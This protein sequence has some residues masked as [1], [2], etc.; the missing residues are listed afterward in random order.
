[1]GRRKLRPINVSREEIGDEELERL[2]R[3]WDEFIVAVRRARARSGER[4]D[5]LTL[6][7]YEFLRPLR[8]AGGMQVTHLADR[9]G[10]APGTATGILDG[11]ARLGFIERT[12]ASED[13]RTVTI[14]LTDAGRQ[15]VE[16][17]RRSIARQ[18]R[19]LFASIAPEERGHTERMLRHLARVITEL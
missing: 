7:Q 16:R 5:G 9:F 12:R 11:L 18:R 1:M 17:K 14:T 2:E 4:G 19:R 6:S 10:I 3:A 15:E 13:R 8:G